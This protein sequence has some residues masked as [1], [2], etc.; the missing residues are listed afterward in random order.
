MDDIARLGIAVDSRGVVRAVDSLDDL[1][2][3][4]AR[5][6]KRTTSFTSKSNSQF[7]LLA[8]TAAAVGVAFAG[9]KLKDKA[10]EA[11]ALSQ[12]YA[13]LGLS[14]QV[15]GKNVGIQ[16][17]VLDK[18][19]V[20]LQEL[21]ISMLKSREVIL[22]L[23]A[24]NIDLSKAEELADLA[25]NA[26]IVGQLNTSDALDRIVNGIRSGES[27]ILKTIGLSVQFGNSYKRLAETLGTTSNNLTENQKIIARTNEALRNAPPLVGLYEKA[28]ENAGKKFR[29][30]DRLVENLSVKIG[31]VFDSTSILA[32]QTYTDIL[33]DLDDEVTSLANNGTLEQ[34]GDR[35]ALIFAEIG[36]SGRTAINTLHTLLAAFATGSQ[37]LQAIL[38]LNFDDVLPLGDAFINATKERFSDLNKLVDE[39]NAR[40]EKRELDKV[41]GLE[42]QAAGLLREEPEGINEAAC[43]TNTG[44]S[45]AA[46]KKLLEDRKQFIAALEQEF[47]QLGKTNVEIRK[48]EAAQLG[49]SKK[50]DVLID[51]IEEKTN[52]LQKEA[53]ILRE[54]ERVTDSVS[55]AEE[56]F[57]ER[58]KDLDVLFSK[59]LG[60]ET[61]TRAIEKSREEIF[62]LERDTETT[63]SAIDQLWIQANRNIQSSLSD[64]FFKA[65]SGNLDGMVDGVKDTVKRIISEFA[66][67]K[68]AEFLGLDNIFGGGK[69]QGLDSAGF[70]QAFNVGASLFSSVKSTFIKAGDALGLTAADSIQEQLSKSPI[71]GNTNGAGTAFIGG[72]N[73]AIGGSGLQGQSVDTIAAGFSQALATSNVQ[74]V[75]Q[76]TNPSKA[77]AVDVG[78]SAADV[79]SSFG[80]AL[81][82][83]SAAVAALSFLDSKFGDFELSKTDKGFE[84]SLNFAFGPGPD[85]VN[86]FGLQAPEELILKAL[87]GRGPLKQKRTE[88]SGE[89]GSEGF[90]DGLVNTRFKAKGGLFKKNK[91][92][93][94]SVGLDGQFDTDEPEILGEFGDNLKIFARDVFGSI[95]DAVVSANADFGSIAK[96]LEINNPLEEFSRQISLVSEKGELLTNEQIAIEI[97]RITD[98][99][100]DS[101]VPGL[102]ELGKTG[103]TSAESIVRFNNEFNLLSSGLNVLGFSAADARREVLG[104]SI[105]TRT[106]LVDAFGG[107]DVFAENIDLFA[108]EF[109]TDSEKIDIA[110][111]SIDKVL[112][113]FDTSFEKLSKDGLG[114]LIKSFLLM[115]EEGAESAQEL[116]GIA[117][118]FISTKDAVEDATDTVNEFSDAARSVTQIRTSL[119]ASY[120]KE[121]I[122]L[123]DTISQFDNFS[124][125]LLSFKDR[126]RLGELSPLTPGQKLDDARQQ[127]N[128]TRRLA[129]SGDEDAIAKLPEIAQ[130][131]L[132]ASQTFNASGGTFGSDFALVQSVLDSVAGNARSEADLARAQLSQLESSVTKLV[133]IDQG[134]ETVDESIKNLTIAV[135]QGSGNPNISDQTIRDVAN[136]PDLSPQEIFDL[137]I[138]NNV[139]GDQFA[140]ATGADP[141]N[142]SVV[143]GGLSVS[144]ED[145]RNFVTQNPDPFFI[146]QTA[147]DF[148]LTFER[149]ANATNTPMGDIEEFARSNGLAFLERG[150]DRTSRDGLAFLHKNESVTPSSVPDEIKMLREEIRRQTDALI[151]VT[152]DSSRQN[153]QMIMKSNK[154]SDQSS[155][156]RDRSSVEVA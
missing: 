125:T 30:T 102:L 106:S 109:L 135:L 83:G 131:F 115:G 111:E 107:L 144:D 150:L 73:T 54:I 53:D 108:K 25:R 84:K 153:A 154:E 32:A 10:I 13:E 58:V 143:T 141:A 57:A 29:S 79:L 91:N 147:K 18:T 87:F 72:P 66:A 85:I 43:N 39:T 95:N 78:A 17:A 19:E 12:R 47:K 101:L 148:G 51:K 15:V 55:T 56:R 5:A 128:Q 140:S 132:Q 156:W 136:N 60:I 63:V 152:R 33:K 155:A 116:F 99:M 133:D 26:A 27:E 6:E 121:R 71:F 113:E 11:A 120:N 48:M 28:M 38:T 81:G 94:V 23:A 16:N 3:A 134:I 146:Y 86:A 82:I 69:S 130:S 110:A 24:A 46:A 138:K 37:Q 40:I 4:G 124:N 21:G 80:S 98:S 119:I 20:K 103:E 77:P 126:L 74:N 139:S 149:I 114:E 14:V 89:L 67:L 104:L 1:A 61:Y 59:G 45:N 142:I 90:I 62:G 41:L 36:D 31:S 123:E 44:V 65:F 117:R 49:A 68:T 2:D 9:L 22:K 92:D 122:A 151:A 7:A 8:K 97:Q 42:A 64:G 112:N 137:A 88:L 118:A 75:D 70:S 129:A 34:W 145:I 76:I 52:S 96:N 35:M 127:F 105:E 93:F 50:A 100:A